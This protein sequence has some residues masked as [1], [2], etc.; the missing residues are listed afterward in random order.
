MILIWKTKSSMPLMLIIVRYPLS[1][2]RKSKAWKNI[3][4]HRKCRF[5]S[6]GWMNSMFVRIQLHGVISLVAIRSWLGLMGSVFY[7][8][9][10]FLISKR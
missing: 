10:L 5:S 3:K 8:F 9:F 2:E 7:L 4:F 1:K 6:Y